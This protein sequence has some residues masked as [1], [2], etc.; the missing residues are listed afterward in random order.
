MGGEV[1]E[2]MLFFLIF[3]IAASL[4]M[5]VMAVREFIQECQKAKRNRI[6]KERGC[7]PIEM[8]KK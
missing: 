1:M 6:I 2:A 4:F 7:L 3:A 5:I 8:E